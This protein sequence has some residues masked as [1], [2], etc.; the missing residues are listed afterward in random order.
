MKAINI[1][2]VAA[3]MGTAVLTDPMKRTKIGMIVQ[4]KKTPKAEFMVGLFVAG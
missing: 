2:K 3:L 1:K 4:R